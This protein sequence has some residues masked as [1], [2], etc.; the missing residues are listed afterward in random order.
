MHSLRTSRHLLQLV[1][2]SALP[3]VSGRGSGT[4][5]GKASPGTSSDALRPCGFHASSSLSPVGAAEQE[6]PLRSPVSHQCRN[7]SGS[8]TR[9][10][11][12]RRGDRLLQ[13]AAQLESKTRT[14]P[15]CPLRGTGRWAIWAVTPT[16]W[17]FPTIAWSR[18]L[19]ERLPFVGAIPPTTTNRNCCL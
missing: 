5:A 2:K 3:E 15:A 8:R 14:S 10:P 17:P 12:S 13:R 19:T 9:S 16:A 11:A 1:R 4:L 18:L 6:D 7:S